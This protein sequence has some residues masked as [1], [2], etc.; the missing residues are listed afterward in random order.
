MPICLYQIFFRLLKLRLSR[1]KNWYFT[2][3]PSHILKFYFLLIKKAD[4]GFWRLLSLTPLQPLS[5]TPSTRKFSIS[6]G[7]PLVFQFF[8]IVKYPKIKKTTVNWPALLHFIWP[9]NFYLTNQLLSDQSKVY[10]TN[11]ILKKNNFL[12][13][14]IFQKIFIYFKSG[15]N[16][17]C[18]YQ[19]LSA[20]VIAE[21]NFHLRSGL[22]NK[23]FCHL[24]IE[25]SN[26]TVL[27]GGTLLV[28]PHIPTIAM[29]S[30]RSIGQE[31]TQQ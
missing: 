27:R 10:L 22:Y 5:L 8:E 6:K 30:Y 20:A 9:K 1:S 2:V 29:T 23:C 15:C 25:C 19:L 3:I 7:P 26:S 13:N 12:T 24:D 14:Q 21:R 18:N 16:H 31:K 4:E 11:Q 28:L 17:E